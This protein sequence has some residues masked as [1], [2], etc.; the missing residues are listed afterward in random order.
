[1]L[2][3]RLSISTPLDKPTI[4]HLPAVCRTAIARNLLGILEGRLVYYA[5]VVTVTNHI[6]RIV[7]PISLRRIIFNLMYATPI[8]GNMR[9]YKTLNRIK[10]RFFWT[11]LRSDVSDWIKIMRSL[12][13]H[14]S[15]AES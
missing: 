12:Y 5:K 3:H 7:V 15:L 1:M 2:I 9:E 8:S 14:L 11:R 10:L 6:C 13:A 4:L